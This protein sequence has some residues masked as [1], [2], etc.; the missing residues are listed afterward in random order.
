MTEINKITRDSWILNTFPEWG[1]WL[2]EEIEETQV[3]EKTFA[4]WWLGCTGIWL[5]SEDNTNILVDLWS[6]TGKRTKKNKKMREGHQMMRMSG[7]EKLQP[8]LRNAP[9]V[10]DPFAIKN[11]DALVVTHIHTDHRSKEHTSELQSRF[12]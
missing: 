3:E 4:M 1:T 5:K 9:F 6:G 12:D 10:I 7:V 11:L 2:N 8:N